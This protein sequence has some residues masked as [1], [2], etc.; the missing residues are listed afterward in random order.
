MHSAYLLVIDDSPDHAQVVNSFLR[1]LGV[2]V[3]VVSASGLDELEIVLNEKTPFLILLGR[4]LPA[5]MKVNQILKAA[6]EHSIPLVMQVQAEDSDNIEAAIATHPL[7]IINSEDD[8]QLLQVVKRHLSGGKTIRE[9]DELSQRQEELQHRYNLLLDSARDSIA[10]IH[11]GLHIYANRAYLDLLQVSALD[12][13]AGISLLELITVD[14]GVNLK[15]LLRDMNEA[16]FPEQ[17]LVVTIN[18]LG[19]KQLEAELTFSPARFNGEQCIQMLAREQDANLVLQEE[20]D[21]LRKTDHL[22]HMINRKT[23]TNKLTELIET[24]QG[25]DH[26]TAVMYIETDGISELQQDLG[27]EGIDT[28]IMDLANIISGCTMEGDIPSRFSDHG[29]AVLIRRDEGSSLQKTGECILENYANHIIDLG[30]QT[31]TAS[32]SIG[33]TTLG[34]LTHDPKEVIAQAKTAFS[35][36]LQK[37]NTLVRYKPAL[38]TVNSGESERDWVERIRYALNNHDFFTVQQSIVDLEGENEG[39]FENRTFMR[40][41]RGDTPAGEFMLAAE[42]ND[43][44]ST[45][46]RHVIP[47]IMLAIAGTGDRHIISLSTNSILDF[48]FPN[49]F[50]RMLTETE[51]EGSQIIL[52]ISAMVAES[53]LKPT[54]RLMEEFQQLGCNF[55][56]SE[57]DNDRRTIQL[58]DHL[59]VH[60][61]KL[62]PGLA[63]GLSSN[64]TNQEIIR[65]VVRAVE[66]RNITIV[67]DEVRDASDLAALWQCGVKLVT[68]D[69][70]NEA[71]QVVGQ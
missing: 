12:E 47:Q 65:T 69:F 26:R 20:L 63:Q 44:G 61:I 31:R 10:Y 29:F 16:T 5:S 2:A 37:G 1:N 21:R 35:Q 34:P 15:Q 53:N 59:P 17:T 46:D 41:E 36:A 49:W 33:M 25:R 7:M 24:G 14:E 30:V 39:L 43:L 62:R 27:M 23:F 57:F 55:V 56:I 48:S 8:E 70:L 13:I 71:P 22:T 6:D 51:V 42:R 18:T 52:Q 60:M 66:A 67:A 40:E 28:Y 4:R 68:G 32:C 50:Q 9:Y 19:G 64:A 45:I 11:E 58:L 38:S 3:R 54:Q